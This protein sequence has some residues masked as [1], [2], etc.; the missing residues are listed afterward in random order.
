MGMVPL[1]SENQNIQ[2]V[3]VIGIELSGKT[4]LNKEWGSG[5]CDNSKKLGELVKMQN[6]GPPNSGHPSDDSD[7]DGP[8]GTFWETPA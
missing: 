7:T 3:L 4:G 5:N 8:L 1:V 6:P 2:P